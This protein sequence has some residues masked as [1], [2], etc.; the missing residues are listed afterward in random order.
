MAKIS[1]IVTTRKEETA[2]GAPIFW[3]PDREKLQTL[4]N[5]LEKVLDCAA[6]QLHEDLIIIVDRN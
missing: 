1:A 4:A 3:T 2:G 6:H 5:L